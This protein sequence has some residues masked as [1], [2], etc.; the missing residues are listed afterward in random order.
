[1]ARAVSRKTPIYFMKSFFG[2]K[3]RLTSQR[4]LCIFFGSGV[5]GRIVPFSSKPADH[6]IP[7]GISDISEFQIVCNP[8]QHGY[9]QIVMT[10]YLSVIVL[11]GTDNMV[12][13]DQV[14]A[15]PRD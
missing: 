8:S 13:G 7:L 15:G 12:R 2:P 11:S 4:W 14:V 6:A 3:F 10:K 1:M 5:T 9:R